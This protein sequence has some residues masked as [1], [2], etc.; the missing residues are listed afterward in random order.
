M[1][2][3][4]L[5]FTAIFCYLVATLLIARAVSVDRRIGEGEDHRQASFRSAF[6]T[7]GIAALVHI[8]YVL[9]TS[10]NDGAVNFSVSSMTTL[11]SAMLVS[12]YLLGCLAMPIKRLGILVFPLTAASLLFSYFWRSEANYLHHYSDAFTAHILISLLAY[13]LLTIATIEALLYVYQER[14]I[15][16]HTTSTMLLALPP[17]QTME[18]LLFRLVDV[19]F[20]LLTLTLL[21]GALFSQQIFG[22]PFEFKHHTVLAVLGW[23]VFAILLFKR[24]RSGLRGSEAVIWI[25]AGFLLIQLGYFGTKIIAES[26]GLQ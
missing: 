2:Y 25:I 26:L 10:Q 14:Q 21:S 16:N 5:L 11:V 23:A 22:Q 3:T 4:L 7:A 6:I 8:A 9:N 18:I 24:Y 20:V 17:L 12:I 1:P 13:S 19:S 15:K